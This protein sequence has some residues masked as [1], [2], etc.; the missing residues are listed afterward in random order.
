MFL[1]S[2]F[3]GK[4]L[5]KKENKLYK[6]H[7]V[8]GFALLACIL[9]FLYLPVM[10]S[11][12]SS[13]LFPYITITVLAV[14]FGISLFK[15]EKEDFK[16]LKT[17]SFYILLVLILVVFKI[18]YPMD[19]GDDSFYIPFI[20]DLTNSPIFSISPRNGYPGFVGNYYVFQ[21]YYLML[22]SINYFMTSS[23]AILFI[24]KTYMS[25]IF[26]IFMSQIFMHIKQELNLKGLVPILISVISVAL[27]GYQSLT[28]I[29]WGSFA[30]FPVFIPLYIIVF[31]KYLKEKT[32][33]N[34]GL[35][36]LLTGAMIF[37]S[38]STLFLI[39]FLALTF[40]LLEL[41]QKKAKSFDYLMIILPN[42]IYLALYLNNYKLLYLIGITIIIIYSLTKKLDVFINK[43]F[44]YSFLAIPIVLTLI[45]K[46]MNIDYSWENYNMGYLVLIFNLVISALIVFVFSKKR[47]IISIPAIFVIFTI[48]FFNPFSAKLIAFVIKP[49]VYHRLFFITKNP[50]VIIVVLNY[51]YNYFKKYHLTKV[52]FNLAILS[53]LVIYGRVIASSSVL[54]K[55]YHQPYNYLYRE[56]EA[57]LDLARHLPKGSVL[58][59]YFQPRIFDVD[60]KG[61]NYRYQSFDELY[62]Y[63]TEPDYESD[64]AYE[65]VLRYE[66]LIIFKDPDLANKLKDFSLKYQNEKYMLLKG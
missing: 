41:Y 26:I 56:E 5:I 66:Y 54:S 17:S 23:L 50:L 14:L 48:C 46:Y 65:T 64:E 62:R 25:L 58:S 8:F 34:I 61:L 13:M 53:L 18:Y 10:L 12:E 32:K 55:N 6:L 57:N 35:L 1:I 16:F 2:N 11:K 31:D 27:V 47:E 63:L 29:Y 19:A 4:L 20:R 44:R 3:L 7:A 51:L 28:H 37:L 9:E 33:D 60:I 24:F 36:M 22:A 38:S 30:L 40:L 52:L 42:L 39:S 45:A 15:I 59:I 49:E 43:Y 21:G